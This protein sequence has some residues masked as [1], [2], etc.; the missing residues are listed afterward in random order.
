M[1]SIIRIFLPVIFLLPAFF[2]HTQEPEAPRFSIGTTSTPTGTSPSLQ[3]FARFQQYNASPTSMMDRYDRTIH[4]PKSVN[5]SYDGAKF[6]V[7][8]LEGFITSIY[9][10]KTMTRI[11]TI[12]H[13]FSEAD[14]GL[15]VDNEYTLF[16][17]SYKYVRD[18]YNI[19]KGKPVESCFSHEGKYLWVT[20]YRRDWDPNAECPSAV[21]IIDTRYDSVVRV[22]PTGPLPKMIAC[23]PDNRYI[24]V[25]HWGD[26]TVGIIDIS[27]DTV[28]QFEYVNH[29]IVDKRAKM[30]FSGKVNRDANCG[31]CLRGT[32]FSSDS[33]Y[34]LIG[35]MSG[36]GGIAV[37][38]MNSF[39]YLG[40]VQGTKSNLRHM[41][42]NNGDLIVS[43]NVSGFVQRAALNDL[44]SA[45]VND[46]LPTINY[47][48]WKSCYVGKG[49]RTI[50]ATADGK[51]IFASV[52]NESK[53]AVI[54]AKDMK[55]VC[56]IDADAYPVGMAL[57]PDEQYLIATSQGRNRKGGNSVV[58]YKIQY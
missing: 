12:K 8:S 2:V 37:F 54:R 26:N 29:L 14:S 16:D 33:N 42:I 20:Y 22:M 23:S 6:Y 50:D 31:H 56:T 1:K 48:N 55:L 28:Q 58:V 40:T 53:V 36:A 18:Q 15:F 30:D 49:V 19:F 38:D 32:V 4:S 52:N 44:L 9:D 5:F 51:Y 41:I 27:S 43:T 21:A 10:T 46:T 13:D 24:A 45:R 3:I 57:S 17:Y 11:K 47:L 34:L 7:H 39:K 35:K 25:T